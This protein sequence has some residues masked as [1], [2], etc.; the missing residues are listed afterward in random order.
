MAPSNSHYLSSTITLRL[1]SLFE[2]YQVSRLARSSML[3]CYYTA[4]KLYKAGGA[5]TQTRLKS[6]L[7]VSLLF[8]V[9]LTLSHDMKKAFD[10][11]LL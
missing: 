4:V 6:T 11:K 2:F 3:A 10:F 5:V 7:S 9:M 1:G 8:K